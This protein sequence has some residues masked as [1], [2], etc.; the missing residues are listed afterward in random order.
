MMSTFAQQAAGTGGPC[1]QP[2]PDSDGSIA[3]PNHSFEYNAY[4]A[5]QLFTTLEGAPY[6]LHQ[7][8]NWEPEPVGLYNSHMTADPC[9][10]A[11]NTIADA[12][13]YTISYPLMSGSYDMN[14]SESSQSQDTLSTD[15]QLQSN[16]AFYPQAD[17][18]QVTA[19][20]TVLTTTEF[21][22]PTC[23]CPALLEPAVTRPPRRSRRRTSRRTTIS[24]TSQ[25]SS[26][27][28]P[29][30]RTYKRRNVQV[31]SELA[32]MSVQPNTS[33]TNSWRCPHCT[34]VQHN[35]R[36]P[37]FNRHIATHSPT[38]KVQW[39]CCG[40]PVFDAHAQG[41]PESVIHEEPF[42]HEG[43]PMVGG[44]KRTFSRRD[45]LSRHL[46][47]RKG[48]CFGDASAIYQAGNS[49]GRKPGL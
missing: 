38:E 41:V 31:P 42:E 40:V 14:T 34:Y 43:L 35:R 49:V 19:Q 6:V 28:A 29:K 48:L 30:L 8:S 37:D 27:P 9:D 25:L 20:P 23:I 10:P 21:A 12:S 2:Y 33:H 24:S 1:Y 7:S 15:P 18:G 4:G 11:M 36:S 13:S 16:D 39:V 44:C 5:Q 22:E 32:A 3:Q 26:S 17:V 46:G 45:A 47:S